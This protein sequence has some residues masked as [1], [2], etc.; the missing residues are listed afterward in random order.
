MLGT[1]GHYAGRVLQL[2]TPTVTRAN[3][4]NGYFRGPLTL[5]PVTQ[6]LTV[7]TCTTYVCRGWD[8]NIRLSACEATA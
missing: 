3:P 1:H 2:A 4:Y 7:T 6:R 8:S 5:T